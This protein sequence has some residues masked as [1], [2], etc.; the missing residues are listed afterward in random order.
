MNNR[1][2]RLHIGGGK[3]IYESS[4]IGIFDMDTATQSQNTKKF[5]S[6]AEKAGR[7]EIVSEELPKSFVVT[8]ECV[9]LSQLAPH[10]LVQRME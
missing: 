3:N 1:W 9:Y 6:H 5:L 8:D 10:T 7:V 4:I 2:K